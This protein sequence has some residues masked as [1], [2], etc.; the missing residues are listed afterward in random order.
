M[1]PPC[2][3]H[4]TPMPSPCRLHAVPMRSPCRPHAVPKQQRDF[5]LVLREA[6]APK[7]RTCKP[8]PAGACGTGH[9]RAGGSEPRSHRTGAPAPPEGL[10]CGDVRAQ[11]SPQSQ[12]RV[13]HPTRG[14][15]SC[16]APGNRSFPFAARD[17]LSRAR[18]QSQTG[19]ELWSTQHGGQ[20]VLRRWGRLPRPLAGREG[21]GTP[22]TGAT[23]DPSA[24]TRALPPGDLAAPSGVLAA[25]LPWRPSARRQANRLVT[26]VPGLV[27]SPPGGTQGTGWAGA[28]Q[29]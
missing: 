9:P 8:R 24:P 15:H 3:P 12:G 5:H 6:A 1:P 14:P 11:A 23:L 20:A 17:R 13:T 28:A 26:S 29:V 4:S 10:P 21:A 25:V 7:I 18:V 19:R 27:R 2:H 16:P 22:S